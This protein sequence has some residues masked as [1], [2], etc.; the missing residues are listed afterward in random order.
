MEQH[1]NNTIDKRSR[2][3]KKAR[4]NESE[5]K[6]RNTSHN[7]FLIAFGRQKK[8]NYNFHALKK[9]MP[10]HWRCICTVWVAE[11]SEDEKSQRE[12]NKQIDD[13]KTIVNRNMTQINDEDF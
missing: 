7:W 1:N 3:R 10:L 12:N 8:F 9:S 11:K 6:K 2:A 13:N 5:N 4:W